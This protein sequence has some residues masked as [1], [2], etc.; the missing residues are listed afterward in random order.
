MAHFALNE[1]DTTSCRGVLSALSMNLDV[2]IELDIINEVVIN[3]VMWT[4]TSW[5]AS[6]T[7]SNSTTTSTPSDNHSTPHA[8]SSTD[9]STSNT[10]NSELDIDDDSLFQLFDGAEDL[11]KMEADAE[12]AAV[13]GDTHTPPRD[14]DEILS[15]SCCDQTEEKATPA[16]DSTHLAEVVPDAE[17][18]AEG[19][20]CTE[21]GKVFKFHRVSIFTCTDC[22]ADVI[23]DTGDALTKTEEKAT[24]GSSAPAVVEATQAVD[25][26]PNGLTEV[27]L[28]VETSAEGVADVI[29]DT[30]NQQPKRR[31]Q[32]KGTPK[33]KAPKKRNN[34]SQGEKPHECDFCE[35]AF[36]RKDSMVRHKMIHTGEKPHKCEVC[37][38][39]FVEK[40]ALTVHMRIHTGEKPHQCGICGKGYSAKKYL[41]RHLKNDHD[42]ST[43]RE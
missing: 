2:N 4:S 38:K 19:F 10:N 1:P 35:K 30:G 20:S 37:G 27:V 21:C 29:K 28:D 3:D 18:S 16:V 41:E 7:T 40:S 25:S 13:I 11:L 15:E 12:G 14:P 26:P 8:A 33:K 42:G 31:C 17:T 32:K 34:L 6:T 43:T 9:A 24:P 39:A 22:V 5:F 36:K 23:E